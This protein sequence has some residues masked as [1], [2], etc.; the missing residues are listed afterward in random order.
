MIGIAN[1]AVFPVPVCAQP[2]KSLPDNIIMQLGKVDTNI[3]NCDFRYPIC[4]LQAFGF[5]LASLCR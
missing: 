4:S 1:A 5:A 3:Y 2:T